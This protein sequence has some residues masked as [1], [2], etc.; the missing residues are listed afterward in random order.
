MATAPSDLTAAARIRDA[1][2]ARFAARGVAGTSI[3]DVAKAAGVSPGLV[4][5]HF[6]SKAGL[7]KAVEDFVVQRAVEAFGRPL[8]GSSPRDSSMQ[9]G[10]LISAF[11]RANPAAFA[12][13]GRSLLEGDAAARD[14]LQNF[15]ALARAQVD[16]LLAAGLLRTDLDRDWTALHVILID[17]GAYLMEPALRDVLGASLLEEKGLRRMEHATEQLF[18]RGIYRPRRGARRPRPTAARARISR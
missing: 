11:I 13:L 1:A 14:L 12:Y 10:A 5:H 7:R 15:V 16:R 17:V 4:Q 2:L 8:P 18:L 6:R 9:V 3:R